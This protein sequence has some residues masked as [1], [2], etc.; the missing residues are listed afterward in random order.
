MSQ[1]VKYQTPIF[2]WPLRDNASPYTITFESTGAAGSF[3]V[4]YVYEWEGWKDGFGVFPYLATDL[5]TALN[6]NTQDSNG[7]RCRWVF[8]DGGNISPLQATSCYAL[9]PK[10]VIE[11]TNFEG[12]G[13]GTIVITP[14]SPFDELSVD[15]FGTIGENWLGASGPMTI[16]FAN[17][18]APFEP[19]VQLPYAP[20]GVWN[21]GVLQYG[22]SRNRSRSL[23][24]STN[25]F[26][27]RK[28]IS[29]WGERY[30]REI[31]LPLVRATQLYAY[32][33]VNPLFEL[34]STQRLNPN[35]LYE[36]MIA[37]STRADIPVDIYTEVA[38]SPSE[39]NNT[40]YGAAFKGRRCKIMDKSVLTDDGSAWSYQAEDQR[41]A[42]VTI[43]VMEL[44]DE[45]NTGY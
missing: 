42:N 37:D 40:T 9:A 45:P 35:N 41:M 5:T 2:S 16:N 14:S 39:T 1:T 10:L 7:W 36:A 11:T 19:H 26:S 21:P 22:D 24:M 34:N 30:E 15:Y 25:S 12:Y 38:P 3:P 23:G 20:H 8:G 27:H 28:V 32:R 13:S 43:T 4:P 29:R 33:R 6:F 44:P 31:F 17:S 18:F